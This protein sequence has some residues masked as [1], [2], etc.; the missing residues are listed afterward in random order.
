MTMVVL[1]PGGLCFSHHSQTKIFQV[2]SHLWNPTWGSKSIFLKGPGGCS[3][4]HLEALHA[5]FQQGLRHLSRTVIQVL[6]SLLTVLFKP[7]ITRYPCWPYLKGPLIFQ[8]VKPRSRARKPSLESRNRHTAL[9]SKVQVRH[10]KAARGAITQR[11]NCCIPWK[12][13]H[14]PPPDR[15][16]ARNCSEAPARI[17]GCNQTRKWTSPY[18]NE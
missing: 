16:S 17:S 6:A 13:T 14:V 15:L 10:L 8:G 12:T 2:P 9:A 3:K 18:L 5:A 1:S 7:S 11:E 4:C